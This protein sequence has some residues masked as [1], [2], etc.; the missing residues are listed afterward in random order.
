M[1]QDE[2]HCIYAFYGGLSWMSVEI[3]YR[4][5]IPTIDNSDD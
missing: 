1:L 3:A 5:S 4:I 2:T